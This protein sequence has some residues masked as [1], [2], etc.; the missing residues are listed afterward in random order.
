MYRLKLQYIVAPEVLDPPEARA[1]TFQCDVWSL[2]V[3]L[4]IFLCGATP[5]SEDY[6]PPS[7]KAQIKMGKFEFFPPFWDIIS[8][9]GKDN[10]VLFYLAL[11]TYISRVAK[12]MI[13][14]LLTVDPNERAT[15]DEALNMPW[16][17]MEVSLI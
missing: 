9:E 16:M 14:A 4:Y 3:M 13:K 1:Y 12:D 5:F 8:N 6:A 11:Y 17:K 15:V 7:M 10:K 2:G